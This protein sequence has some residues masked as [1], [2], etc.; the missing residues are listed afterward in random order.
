MDEGFK[1]LQQTVNGNETSW[2]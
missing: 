1:T 2:S